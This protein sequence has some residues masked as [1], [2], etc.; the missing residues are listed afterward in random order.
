M[1][2]KKPTILLVAPYGF[3][4]RL[5]NFIEFVT[6]RLLARE[7]WDVH[8]ITRR[9]GSESRIEVVAGITVHRYILS[10]QGALQ[11]LRLF[12]IARP[13][14]VHVHNLRNNQIG[15]LAALLAKL[16]RTPLFFTE[17]GLPHDHYLSGDRDDPFSAPL[18][19][20]N[21]VGSFR[22]L[23]AR[24]AKHPLQA[25]AHI[26]NYLFHYPLFA[27]QTCAF[28]SRHNI[29]IAQ[30]LGIR[31]ARY[32][33]QIAD[34]VRF[35]IPDSR[36]DVSLHE[37]VVALPRG[38]K[39]LF[40][41][42]FKERKGWETYLRAIP[43]IPKEIISTFILVSPSGDRSEY[44]L[45]VKKLGIEDRISL[46]QKIPGSILKK[47]FGA[48][49]MVIVPSLYEG[50]GLVPLE[51]FEAGK[52][53]IASQVE[54]LIDFLVDGENALLVRPR[55][56]QALADAIM[57]LAGN[58]A[59]QASIAESGTQTLEGLRSKAAHEKWLALYTETL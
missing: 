44:D 49:D 32:I 35:D 46:F 39:A 5:T 52:P 38:T 56:T 29:P 57:R 15:F 42:Q 36:A 2:I 13:S 18:A 6:G 37:R 41:G 25:P 21:V 20:E 12:F 16:T 22:V 26:R 11:L 34:T 55:D 50:F 45:L 58:K 19:Y 9:E 54:A 1:S 14:I 51:A 48:T 43:F 30:K 33:P 10:R 59:L 27:A 3:N 4:D 47:L 40:V 53:I 17:Y 31:D 24:I 7:G 8:A 23:I 28:V